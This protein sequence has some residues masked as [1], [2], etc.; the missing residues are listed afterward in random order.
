MFVFFISRKEC[1]VVTHLLKSSAPQYHSTLRQIIWWVHTDKGTRPHDRLSGGSTLTRTAALGIDQ[2]EGVEGTETCSHSTLVDVAQFGPQHVTNLFVRYDLVLVPDDISKDAK[3]ADNLHKLGGLA[4]PH[5]VVGRHRRLDPVHEDVGISFLTVLNLLQE[6]SDVVSINIVPAS[7]PLWL[8]HIPVWV[9]HGALEALVTIL[10]PVKTVKSCE[11]VSDCFYQ[12]WFVSKELFKLARFCQLLLD[13]LGP[14]KVIVDARRLES[15]RPLHH[16]TR[17]PLP[18]SGILVRMIA[19]AHVNHPHLSLSHPQPFLL[20]QSG[21]LGHLGQGFPD[22]KHFRTLLSN[23]KLMK[24][25][26]ADVVCDVLDEE[27]DCSL[28]SVVNSPRLHHGSCQ[29]L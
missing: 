27:Q 8:Q 22:D 16:Q 3:L 10:I 18:L 14:G 4:G 12:L 28:W 25:L 6:K 19:T 11:D 15:Q 23:L 21:I 26:V 5:H 13:L 7:F 20:T 29:A 2:V 24:L 9:F 17:I 1:K